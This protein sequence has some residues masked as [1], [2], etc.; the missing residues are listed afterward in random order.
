MTLDE[1]FIESQTDKGSTTHCYA[2]HYEKYFEEMRDKEF[3]LLEIG[4][5]AG[6]SM[7]AWKKYFPKAKVYGIDNNPDC[8]GENVFI[9]DQTDFNFLDSVLEKIGI[10]EIV[11]EDGS[12]F[13]P[14]TILTFE[15][16]FPKIAKG[17]WYV[18]EDTHCFYDATYG[19]APPF[20]QGMSRVFN[21]F[22]ALACDVDVHGRG[23]TGNT[24]YAMELDNPNF[25][26]VPKYSPI[27]DSMHIHPSLWLFKRK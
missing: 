19:Q 24:K 14:F 3:V 23:Y 26:P 25:A 13:G 5:S 11:I 18:L 6:G 8:A 17:A 22:T 4:V 2:P 15:H 21:F 7:K 9:G 27:L 16:L 20:G 10:P 12:H 1:I